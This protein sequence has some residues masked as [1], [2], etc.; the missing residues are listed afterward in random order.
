VKNNVVARVAGQQLDVHDLGG[1]VQI[2]VHLDAVFGLESR[3]RVRRQ[4]V[5]PVVDVDKVAAV[6]RRMISV[7][8]R[9]YQQGAQ[10]GDGDYCFLHAGL[11]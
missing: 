8:A 5:G 9:G 10:G 4:V 3:D 6:P 2:V 1:I 11:I 7:T